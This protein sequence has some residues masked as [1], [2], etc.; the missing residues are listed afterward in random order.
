MPARMF[1]CARRSWI[2]RR[3]SFCPWRVWSSPRRIWSTAARCANSWRTTN[4]GGTW[5]TE[6]GKVGCRL[7]C[8]LRFLPLL[9]GDQ[10]NVGKP[11]LHR[12][13]IVS[14]N[15]STWGTSVFIG[16]SPVTAE[17][18]KCLCVCSMY[19]TREDLSI[20]LTKFIFSFF[21]ADPGAEI[22]PK[23]SKQKIPYTFCIRDFLYQILMCTGRPWL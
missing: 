6:K 11:Y 8:L 22:R 15:N 9:D 2:C 5:R 1:F 4:T 16:A 20:K 10:E 12:I 21:R 3:G 14:R 23:H 18:I 17:N 13:L 19:H 7:P